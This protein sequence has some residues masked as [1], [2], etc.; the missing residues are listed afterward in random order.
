MNQPTSCNLRCPRKAS[1]ARKILLDLLGP[2]DKP[3]IGYA[4]N[5]G[6][7]SPWPKVPPVYYRVA[8]HRMKKKGM[9]KEARR[10]GKKFLKLTKRGKVQALLCRVEQCPR[11]HPR[12]W[13]GK[14]WLALF[15]IPEM[16]KL[17]RNRIR[18]TLKGV[19]FYCLQKSVY[20]WPYELPDDLIVYLND[21]GLGRYIRLVRVDR[22]DDDRKLKRMF[23]LR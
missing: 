17:L 16:G 22:L 5:V 18:K 9:V 23:K 2:V 19:G 1:A 3:T 10:G 20:I 12:T 15:D 7:F 13:N 6:G 4:Y 21:S 8:I 11:P 14:W